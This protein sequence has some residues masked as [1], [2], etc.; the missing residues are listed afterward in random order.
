MLVL[1]LFMFGPAVKSQTVSELLDGYFSYNRFWGSVVLL[2]D[3]KVMFQKSYGYA[4][5]EL[6]KSNDAQTLFD[7]GSVTKTMTAVAILKLHDEG[8]LSVY[9]RVDKYIPG[10]INDK[11]DSVTILNLLNHTSGM[12]AN[13]GR[14]D[15]RGIGI[16][17]GNEPIGR[18]QLIDKFRSSKLKSKPS[19]SYEY[20]NY[21]YTLLAYILEKVSGMDYATYLK[22]VIFDPLK[23][24]NTRYKLDLVAQPAKGYMGVGTNDIKAVS[25]PFHPSWIVGAGYVYSSTNDLSR[26]VSAVFTHKLFSESTLRLMMDSCVNAGKQNKQWALGWERKKIDGLDWY[27]HGGGVFGFST[28]VGYLPEKGITVIILSNLVKEMNFDEI[29]SA[30]F[31]FVDEITEKILMILNHKTVAYLPVPK[32]KASKK[33]TGTYQFD[34]A[35]HATVFLQ[36][37][38]LFLTAEAKDNFT[39]F[40]YSLNRSQTD[41]TGNYSTCQLLVKSLM[42]ANFEGFEK[43]CVAGMFNP[44]IAGQVS[45]VW[46]FYLSKGGPV[47]S[48]NIFSK[49]ASNYTIAFHLE[50]AEIVMPVFFNDQHLIKG[51]FFQSVLPKCTVQ[52]VHLVPA[53][54]D[55]YVV[56]GY[57]NGGYSDFRVKYDSSAQQ[58][59]FVTDVDS[60]TASKVR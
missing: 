55:E 36:N 57:R 50:K 42:T 11:T 23:M 30:K 41:T 19:T 8:K 3:D 9:D 48:Y 58:L 37:D 24:V 52:T 35:H 6:K 13:L 10:F 27:S 29:Y 22:Q 25:D 20:N 32:G 39:L 33:V 45:N 44:K 51:M 53:G 18:E 46:K 43:N 14:K 4:D 49:S 7:L 31:S 2:Q 54:K 21:G 56:D 38:S 60:F 16:M 5:K 15:E 17:P 40:D 12:E 1:V 59:S 28:K 47:S 26:Y 34:K